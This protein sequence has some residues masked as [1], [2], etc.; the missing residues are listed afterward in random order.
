[1]FLDNKYKELYFKIINRSIGRTLNCYTEDHH[2]IPRSMGGTDESFNLV[3]LTAKEHYVCHLLLVKFT[4]GDS[5]SK[6]AKAV[7]MMKGKNN[8]ENYS[9]KM[10]AKL[11]ELCS[12]EQS[13]RSLEMWS[14]KEFRN[15]MILKKIGRVNS[16]FTKIKMSESAKLRHKMNPLSEESKA[17]M[18]QKLT[19]RILSEEQKAAIKLSSIGI[20]KPGTSEKLKGRILD[21]VTCPHCGKI[22]AGGS[23]K[24]WHFDNCKERT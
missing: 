4:F 2:I 3:A 7:W 16:E 18:R 9:S 15:E 11:Q 1:M 12:L 19:G 8:R 10:Y 20:K 21:E 17:S 13:N 23:M 6:M 14:N 24:R 5:K 22:G